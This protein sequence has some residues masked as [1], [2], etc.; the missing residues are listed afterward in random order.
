MAKRR[1]S[2]L[3]SGYV[4]APKEE[5]EGYDKET[6]IRKVASGPNKGHEFVQVRFNRSTEPHTLSQ[7]T[8]KIFPANGETFTETERK[9][10]RPEHGYNFTLTSDPR[11]GDRTPRP[12]GHGRYPASARLHT[13]G[14]FPAVEPN[15]RASRKAFDRI[16]SQQKEQHAQ[17]YGMQKAEERAN[18]IQAQE[19]WVNGLDKRSLTGVVKGEPAVVYDERLDQVVSRIPVVPDDPGISQ[20]ELSDTGTVSIHVPYGQNFQEG[21]EVS[22]QDV[23]A[24]TNKRGK[25]NFYTVNPESVKLTNRLNADRDPDSREVSGAVKRI[26]PAKDGKGFD[27]YTVHEQHAIVAGEDMVKR[28]NLII[29]RVSEETGKALQAEK[30]ARGKDGADLTL[31][32]SGKVSYAK[33]IQT[34]RFTDEETGKETKVKKPVVRTHVDLTTGSGK[35]NTSLRIDGRKPSELGQAK[36]KTATRAKAPAKARKD[37]R[38]QNT[39]R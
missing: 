11:T 36:A 37:T 7:D 4:E 19:D 31:S 13:D 29:A 10:L 38:S 2:S 5:Y 33:G 23:G 9:A 30:E 24:Y 32:G 17:E 18:A 22:L 15:S 12:G 39:G 6:G 8:V 14:A 16:A 34:Y 1:T 27:V 26:Y 35:D 21:D 25:L 28:D 20:A 3:I